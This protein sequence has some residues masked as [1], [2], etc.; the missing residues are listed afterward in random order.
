[1]GNGGWKMISCYYYTIRCNRCDGTGFLN[2]EQ[3]PQDIVD[4][5]VD[6]ILVY[7]RQVRTIHDVQVCDCCGNG[8]TWYGTPG[9]HYGL[10]DPPGDSGHYA[11]NGGLCECH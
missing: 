10:N 3:V 8:E 9:E 1:M 5:G 6:T 4:R 2:I 11:Y 7:V